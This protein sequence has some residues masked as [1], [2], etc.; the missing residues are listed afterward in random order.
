MKSVPDLGRKEGVVD[1]SL[2]LIDIDVGWHDV[3]IA[4]EA[5]GAFKESRSFARREQPFE[6]EQFVIEIGSRSGIAVRE[7]KAADDNPRTIA[8]IYRLWH[9]A[10]GVHDKKTMVPV[11]IAFRAER[12][13]RFSGRILLWLIP[14]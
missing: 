12:R 10:S 2:G 5:T 14:F 8:S 13:P 4:N 9:T 7:V 11:Y 3:V 6:P 1:P